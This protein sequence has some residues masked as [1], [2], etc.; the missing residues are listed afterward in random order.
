MQMFEAWR[1]ADVT[2]QYLSSIVYV[3]GC[4]L[5]GGG[6]G[7]CPC[8]HRQMTHSLTWTKPSEACFVPPRGLVWLNSSH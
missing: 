5:G 7:E 4:V 6:E 2:S 3:C 1:S 8:I